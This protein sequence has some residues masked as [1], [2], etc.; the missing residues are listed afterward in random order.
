MKAIDATAMPFALAPSQSPVG[1]LLL[2]LRR[3]AALAW[4]QLREAT[5]PKWRG[6]PE[7]S[8][9]PDEQVAHSPDDYWNDPQFWMCIMPH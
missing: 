8:E 3:R 2:L 5:G 9:D 1:G 6:S 4:A 7:P